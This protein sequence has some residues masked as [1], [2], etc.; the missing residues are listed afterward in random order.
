MI[1]QKTA[2]KRGNVCCLL[3]ENFLRNIYYILCN[4]YYLYNR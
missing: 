1:R 4:V 2:E 3:Y